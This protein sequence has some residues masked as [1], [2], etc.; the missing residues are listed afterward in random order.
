MEIRWFVRIQVR[1]KFN[2]IQVMIVG[3]FLK[4]KQ[5]FKF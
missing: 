5:G 1:G 3:A 4:E 2:Q